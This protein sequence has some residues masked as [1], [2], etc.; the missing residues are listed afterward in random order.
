LIICV[1]VRI[2]RGGCYHRVLA[3]ITA[4]V[5][6]LSKAF[7]RGS[8]DQLVSGTATSSLRVSRINHRMG[9]S[10][11]HSSSV[12]LI[13]SRMVSRHLV[14]EIQ[15]PPPSREVLLILLRGVSAM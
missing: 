9:I 10:I 8:R 6:I 14:Q 13:D 5:S 3:V 4:N 2:R 1:K 11:L 12:I 15:M 7:N